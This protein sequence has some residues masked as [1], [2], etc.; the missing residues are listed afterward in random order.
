MQQTLLKD[1]EIEIAGVYADPT[2]ALRLLP[3]IKPDVV[4]LDMEMP[5]MRGTEFLRRALPAN[6]KV[7]VVVISALSNNVFDAMQ[8]GAV[9]FIAKPNAGQGYTNE[10]F[11]EDV[12]QKIKAAA[13]A[14]TPGFMGGRGREPVS[15]RGGDFISSAT[16]AN[17]TNANASIFNAKTP[18]SAANTSATNT[19]ASITSASITS[20]SNTNASI[21]S[22]SA[23]ADTAT[24]DTAARGFSIS[25]AFPGA[26]KGKLWKVSAKDIIAIGA[27][28]GGTEAI[29]R[30]IQ[31]FPEDMPGVV[32]VQHM[33]PG[34]TR[35]YAERANKVCHMTVREAR[36]QD[37]VEQGLILVAPGGHEQ[38][39]VVRSGNSYVV[40]LK[41]EPKV[42]GHC[43]SV[44][45]LFESVARAAGRFA[46]GIILTGMGA[47]GARS[48]KQMRDT[49]AYTIG[50]DEASCVVYGMPKEAYTMGGVVEQLPLGSIASAVVKRYY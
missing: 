28:T 15:R 49:G 42:S 8:A 26:D 12:I 25:Q 47:D 14:K 10:D 37:Q 17:A 34:F 35:M 29:L 4:A 36:N 41:D 1:R 21:A 40:E 3:E 2:E 30:I 44:D 24:T 20:A 23:P 22:A 27:S 16:N 50:Q 13:A 38:F 7:K 48:L 32:I 9:D 5:K 19:N 43:P 18:T 39:R 31:D 46:V 6:P 11:R 45:V 33:P